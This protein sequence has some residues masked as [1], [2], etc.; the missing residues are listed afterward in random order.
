MA[1]DSVSLTG[2]RIVTY[3]SCKDTVLSPEPDVTALIGPN[4]VGKTNLMHA[5]LLLENSGRGAFYGRDS[6]LLTSKC[7]I[8]ATFSYAGKRINCRSSIIYRQDE[9]TRDQVVSSEEEWNFRELTGSKKWVKGQVLQ[10]HSRIMTNHDYVIHA[11][12][13]HYLAEARVGQLVRRRII[14]SS[15]LFKKPPK[16]EL[17]AFEAIRKF[18]MSIQY[19]SASQFTNPALCPTSFEID[20]EEGGRLVDSVQARRS[21]H[22]RFI[23]DLYRACQKNEDSY[24]AFMSIVGKTGVG[25]IDKIEWKTVSLSSENYEVRTGGKLVQKTRNRIIVIP[26]VE[27]GTSQLSFNQLSEGTLRTIAMLFY[28]ITQKS[29]LL[30]LEEPEVCVHHGLLRSVIE[31]V[32]E[33]GSS[34]Q[35]VI[36][37]HS[38]SV[39]DYL[40]PSQLRIVR[41][42]DETGTKVASLGDVLS[43]KELSALRNYLSSVGGLGEYWRHSGFG[44]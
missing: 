30:L 32:K 22:T 41:R 34:K 24:N 29:E 1:G 18:R 20:D 11:G 26:I 19:Y 4:G 42:E 16:E 43:S 17:E 39:L 3:R 27:L 28:I 5:I 12:G 15:K 2:F 36:S 40:S 37:T 7:Q 44:A 6:D 25:L 10:F 21:A 13:R 35:I 8:E 9:S 31:I 23:Y 38:E 14:P 33:Y